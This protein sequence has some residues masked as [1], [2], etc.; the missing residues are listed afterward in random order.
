[1]MRVVLDTNVLVS[2]LLSP[3]QAPGRILDL[4]LAGEFTPVF[5]DRILAEYREVLTRPKFTFDKSAVD[6][7]LLY[8]ERVGT[9]VSALPWHVDLPDPDDGI[10]LEVASTAQA[11]LVS[12]NLRHYPPDL[13]R[14]VIVLSPSAF[15]EHWQQ[16]QT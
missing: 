16:Q 15:I 13:C 6:D 4:V 2:G 7:L 12:G 9:A 3:F 5:D 1:M 14:D 10:F 8:F 11:M